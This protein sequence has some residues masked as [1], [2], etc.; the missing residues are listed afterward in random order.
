MD[1]FFKP[2]LE[3]LALAW[4]SIT[5]L[6]LL[7]LGYRGVIANREEDQLYLAKGEEHMLVEQQ[8]VAGTLIKLSKPLWV[9]GIL[10]GL[11]LITMICFWL[12]QGMQSNHL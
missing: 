8:A 12:W 5:V 3:Y 6:W 7:V 11:L 9:L 10:S 1:D 2:P 4:A